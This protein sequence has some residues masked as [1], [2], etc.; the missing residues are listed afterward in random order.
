MFNYCLTG[1]LA[2][3]VAL[4]EKQE[5][6]SGRRTTGDQTRF[7]ECPTK[8]SSQ[9]KHGLMDLGLRI[10]DVMGYA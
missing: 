2:N 8:S 3:G 7:E 10:S 4:K 6:S 9:A 1:F 5:N